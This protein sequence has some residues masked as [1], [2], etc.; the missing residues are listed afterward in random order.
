M[1]FLNAILSFQPDFQ[2]RVRNNDLRLPRVN[3][4]RFRQSIIY[5]GLSLWKKLPENIKMIR[6][7]S[8]FKKKCKENFIETY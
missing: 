5:Q 1:N 8:Q 2:Y 6:S 4:Y 3:I 7:V